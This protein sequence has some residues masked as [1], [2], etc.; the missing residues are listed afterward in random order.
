MSIPQML[1]TYLLIK[2]PGNKTTYKRLNYR[3]GV[4][5]AYVIKE[6]IWTEINGMSDRITARA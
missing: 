6:K 3:S 1:V 2:Q 5:F 4:M